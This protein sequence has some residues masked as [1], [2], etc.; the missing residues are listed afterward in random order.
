MRPFTAITKYIIAFAV[1]MV[2]FA[3]A[4][5]ANTHHA[6]EI[7]KYLISQLKD[8]T[9][10]RARQCIK[11]LN[12]INLRSEKDA[13]E[14]YKTANHYLYLSHLAGET[15]SV[16]RLQH[17]MMR[18]LRQTPR[19]SVTDT[20]N[21]INMHVHMGA[22][23]DEAGMPGV[24]LDY[25]MKGI[26]LCVDTI[27]D[28]NKAMLHNN[29]GVLYAKSKLYKNAQSHLKQSLKIN[30]EKKI[31]HE[32][33]LN[34]VNLT[35]LYVLLGDY[36]AAHSTSQSGLDHLDSNQYP[37]QLGDMRVHQGSIY[38]A[39]GQYDIAMM[40]YQS[41]LDQYRKCGSKGGMAEA[42]L[43]MGE[44][45]LARSLPQSALTYANKALE[46]S[47]TSGLNDVTVRALTLLSR[48]HEQSNHTDTAVEL[49]RR[50]DEMSDSLRIS[51]SQLRLRQWDAWGEQI[52]P[53]VTDNSRGLWPWVAAVITL[54]ILVILAVIFYLRA[55]R[56][57]K[58]ETCPTISDISLQQEIDERNREMASLTMQR[59]GE[60]EE[61][62]STCDELRRVILEL[63]PRD[64]VKK[65]HLKVLLGKLNSLASRGD[66]EEFRQYFERVHPTFY[67][68]LDERYPTLTER[69]RRLCAYLYL[70]LSTKEIARLTSREVRSV[71]SA[72]NRLRKKLSANAAEDLMQMLRSLN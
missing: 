38:A 1:A 41:A 10:Q 35:E 39:E 7:R 68:M 69:D 9:T 44:A 53:V 67:K 19:L 60:H 47:E 28:R 25:Y 37:T 54:A 24:A 13:N 48:I 12:S 43:S 27:Y 61:L 64:S 6:S 26:D 71:E 30:L 21:L 66:N 45:E 22:T 31:H 2:V 11:S 33:F 50:A 3:C 8:D 55:K 4:D 15:S 58:S 65:S 42:Y 62:A 59:I 34:Y 40:R 63:N 16:L 57:S 49:L 51:E 17:G 56:Q 46:I 20:R 32:A 52:V 70:G 18:Q 23:Y 14:V 29:I 36:A 5:N 72:R